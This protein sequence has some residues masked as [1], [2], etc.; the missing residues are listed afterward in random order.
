[1]LSKKVKSRILFLSISSFLAI[2]IIFIVLKSLEKNVV[3]FFSPT[4]IFYDKEINFEK[5]IRIGGLVKKNSLEKNENRI[6]TQVQGQMPSMTVI[7]I[8]VLS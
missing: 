8:I 1:M 6:I 7:S 3:Y 4:E 5:K 2:L